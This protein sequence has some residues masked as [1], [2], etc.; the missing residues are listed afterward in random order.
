MSHP[1]DPSQ[2]PIDDFLDGDDE[3]DDGDG[4]DGSPAP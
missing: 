2:Q 1:T 4:P 3:P